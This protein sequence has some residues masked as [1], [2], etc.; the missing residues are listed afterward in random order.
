MIFSEPIIQ[1]KRRCK[2][3]TCNKNIFLEIRGA[4]HGQGTKGLQWNIEEAACTII[5]L[6]IV[7]KKFFL[8]R[9]LT[10]NF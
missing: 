5:A 8:W 7:L 1:R 6:G 10:F 4:K 2:R 3:Q 9:K